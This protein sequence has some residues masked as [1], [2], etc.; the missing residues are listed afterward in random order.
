MGRPVRRQVV[1][2]DS[3]HHAGRRTGGLEPPGER[4][5]RRVSARRQRFS[6][7]T[8][9]TRERGCSL[10]RHCD[11]GETMSGYQP[12]RGRIVLTLALAILLAVAAP[13]RVQHGAANGEWRYYGGD[14]GSTKYSPLDQ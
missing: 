3:A 7:G 8:N 4:R 6:R 9:G 10:E 11:Q 12:A 2:R 5:R 14:S 13:V 1:R